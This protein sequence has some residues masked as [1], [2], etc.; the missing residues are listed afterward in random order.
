ML[1]E[2]QLKLCA[3]NPAYAALHQAELE[4][5][6]QARGIVMP[7]APAKQQRELSQKLVRLNEATGRAE[8][9]NLQR[10]VPTRWRVTVSRQREQAEKDEHGNDIFKDETL[11]GPVS[12]QLCVPDVLTHIQRKGIEGPVMM[13]FASIAGDDAFEFEMSVEPEAEATAAPRAI[14]PNAGLPEMMAM[15]MAQQERQAQMLLSAVAKMTEK[16]TATEQAWQRKLDEAQQRHS[17]QMQDLLNRQAAQF[18]GD[19]RLQIG[20]AIEQAFL[21]ATNTAVERSFANMLNPQAPMQQAPQPMVATTPIQSLAQLVQGMKADQE[22]KELLA[23]ELPGLLGGGKAPE[24]TLLDQVQ[25]LLPVFMLLKNMGGKSGPDLENAMKAFM[26]QRGP[27][28]TPPI[29][30]NPITGMPIPDA[31]PSDGDAALQQLANLSGG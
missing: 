27:G 21:Q 5:M 12:A 15:F 4:A 1:T 19:K 22:A 26:T 29:N 18:Q 11:L 24:P 13:R 30:V 2:K 17:Q 28:S 6:G 14:S 20:G 16:A 31:A 10:V 3:Q 25:Q 23:R 8:E 9:V 7:E